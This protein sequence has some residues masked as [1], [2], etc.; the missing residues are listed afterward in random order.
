MLNSTDI[1]PQLASNIRSMMSKL[2]GVYA[3]RC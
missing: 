2:L 3:I 1:K